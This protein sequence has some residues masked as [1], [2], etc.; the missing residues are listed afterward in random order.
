MPRKAKIRSFSF[1]TKTISDL[2]L[3]HEAYF[4]WFLLIDVVNAMFL[5]L[6]LSLSLSQ[7]GQIEEILLLKEA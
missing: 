4:L 3:Y 7:Q 5:S 2:P 6:S 1:M